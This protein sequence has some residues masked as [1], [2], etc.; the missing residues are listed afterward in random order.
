MADVFTKT[1]PHA[2]YLLHSGPQFMTE[3]VDGREGSWIDR[4]ADIERSQ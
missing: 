2:G 3:V 4:S 1:V